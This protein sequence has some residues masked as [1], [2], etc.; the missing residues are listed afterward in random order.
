MCRIRLRLAAM[1]LGAQVVC[2]KCFIGHEGVEGQ[3]LDQRNRPIGTVNG[4]VKVGQRA[5]QN[6]AT[7]GLARMPH[8]CAPASGRPRFSW[9]WRL[10]GCFGPSGPNTCDVGV[11]LRNS[12]TQTS[13]SRC[14]GQKQGLTSCCKRARARWMAPCARS[15]SNG[16][17]G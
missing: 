13:V 5:A 8:E 3:P 17:L 1:Q 9:S 2:V 16:I 10:P 6:V 4:R 15:S 12:S 7:L 14:V 11:G